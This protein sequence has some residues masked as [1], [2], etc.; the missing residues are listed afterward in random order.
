MWQTEKGARFL[1][2][3]GEVS[4]PQGQTDHVEQVTTLARRG[5]L[6]LSPLGESLSRTKRDRPGVL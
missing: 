3:M 1:S 4:E 5:I 2:D 6:P